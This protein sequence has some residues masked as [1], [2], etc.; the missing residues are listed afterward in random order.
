VPQ[1]HNKNGTAKT[2]ANQR[3]NGGESAAK[4][5]LSIPS[6]RQ[7]GCGVSNSIAVE[8]VTALL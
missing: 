2:A 7:H 5:R 6:K 8:S 3:Q 1:N 4:R